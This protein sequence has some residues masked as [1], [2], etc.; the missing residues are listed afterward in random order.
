MAGGS[1][2]PTRRL[3][4]A[5]FS[6]TTAESPSW[7]N[8]NAVAVPAGPPPSTITSTSILAFGLNVALTLLH[9]EAEAVPELHHVGHVVDEIAR[10]RNLRAA[11]LG[12]DVVGSLRRPP[13]ELSLL[14][15]IVKVGLPRHGHLLRHVARRHLFR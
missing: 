6:I 13:A 10:P 12:E 3:P 1:V 14:L 15:A 4:Y 9:D 2:S 7:R 11:G 8:A 5:D